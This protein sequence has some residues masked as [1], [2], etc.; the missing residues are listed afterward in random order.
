MWMR[1]Y[2]SFTEED[3][4]DCE[5]RME[6]GRW[7]MGGKTQIIRKDSHKWRTGGV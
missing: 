6:G 2:E 3:C 5:K 4:E 1:W 7:L